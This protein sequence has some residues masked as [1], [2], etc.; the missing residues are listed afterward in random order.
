MPYTNCGKC[1][2]RFFQHED[3][4]LC[5][6]SVACEK[7]SK[8]EKETVKLKLTKDECRRVL[9]ALSL[10]GSVTLNLAGIY[11]GVSGGSRSES[12][13]NAYKDYMLTSRTMNHFYV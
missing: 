10:L 1:G 12:Q 8:E 11:P 3:E 6:D 2:R 4:S 13:E 7:R 5:A 9:K